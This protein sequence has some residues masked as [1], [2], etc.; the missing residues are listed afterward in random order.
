MTIELIYDRDCPNVAA[1]RTNLRRACEEAGCLPEWLEW[2]RGAPASPAYAA[3]YGS[4]S[5]LIEGKDVAGDQPMNGQASCRLY[6][7]EPGG[8]AGAPSVSLISKALMGADHAPAQRSSGSVRQAFLTLPGA[9]FAILPVGG[10]P[11]CWPLY[12]GALSAL[13]LSFL[14]SSAYLLPITGLFLFV[15]VASLGYGANNRRGYGP[16]AVG[17]AAAALV[18]TGKFVLQ[19]EPAAYAGLGLLVL[20]SLWNAWPRR[21]AACC[22]SGDR[23]GSGLID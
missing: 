16:L 21:V 14:L 8:Y 6:A 3:L 13:G 10:C 1:V 22:P 12:A 5:V 2:E 18:L 15:A 9:V 17:A 4:P 7:A 19:S 20:A 23:K 11:A